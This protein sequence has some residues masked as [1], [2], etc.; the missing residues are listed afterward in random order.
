M[1]L[2]LLKAGSCLSSIAAATMPMCTTAQT[3]IDTETAVP[4]ATSSS[5]DITIAEDGSI[6]LAGGSAVTVDSANQ[7]MNEG[8]I[9]I[10]DGDGASGI[11]FVPGVAS[12]L[13]NNGTIQI[14]EDYDIPD[15][16]ANGTADGAIAEAT[17]RHGIYLAPGGML[18]GSI[19]NSGA[20]GVE[21]LGSG[22][23]ML[24]STLDGSLV[25]S[26]TIAVV[27]DNSVGISTADVTGDVAVT[28][29]VIAAGEGASAVVINGDI[30]GSLLLQNTI[31]QTSSVTGDDGYVYSL[32][33]GDLRSGAPTVSVAGNVGSGII[34]GIPPT[35]EDD[36]ND[37]EDGDGVADDEEGTGAIT[38]YGT[39]AALSIGSVDD[40]AIGATA[41]AGGGHSLEVDGTITSNAVY[42]SN[43]T[44]A[45]LIG[46]QGGAVNMAGGI[47]VN[48][49]IQAVTNDSGAT[50]ILIAE[51]A[52][53]PL[54][55]N[56]G[57]II[58]SISAQGD[59]SS[60][61]I[62]D[63]SG[64]LTTI[65]NNG[66]I[67][68]SGSNEDV[69]A[70]LDLSANT[71]GV[72]INQ[73][74]SDYEDTDGDGSVD[75]EEEAIINTSITGDILT[76]SGDDLI[77][78]SDG[79]I[80]GDS[81]LGAGDDAI[82]LSG[83][84]IYLGDAH[85]AAGTA[86]V[87]LA[88]TS[89]FAGALDVADQA[90]TLTIS[91]A[92]TFLG[93]IEGGSALDVEVNGGMFGASS[94]DELSFSSLHIGAD[95]TL[96]AY[97][98]TESG[99]SSLVSVGTAQFDEG[100][101][102]AVTVS[103]LAGVEGEYLVLS[104]D[105]LVGA[106]SF[107]DS[108]ALLPFLLAGNV[109]TDQ[110]AGEILLQIRQK[111]AAELGLNAALASAYPA[112]L[113]LSGVDE[114]IEASFL[115]IADAE[116]LATQLNGLLPDYSGGNFDLAVRGSRLISRHLTDD[117][118]IFAED[119]SSGLWLEGIGLRGGKANGSTAGYD[120][121]AF[122]ISAGYEAVT[123][124][125]N[126]GLS[127]GWL[128]G[129][130]DSTAADASIGA[131]QYELGAFWRTSR[132]PF[133]AFARGS[134]AYLSY[135]S[136]RTFTGAIDATEYTRST[137]GDWNGFLYSG[138]LGA[139]YDWSLGRRLSVLPKVTVDYYKLHESG[140]S[141]SGDG[142]IDLTVA[143]RDSDALSA[144]ATATLAYA[145]GN[146][147]Y[148]DLPL[149]LEIEAGRRTIIDSALGDTVAHFVDGEDF[150]LAGGAYSGGGWLGEARVRGGGYGY[151]WLLGAGA[152]EGDGKMDFTLRASL[153]VGF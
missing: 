109:T 32:S 135:S 39:G 35:D 144:T 25:H 110:D 84:G 68:A 145:L 105:E 86:T 103:S 60:H 94:A 149:T 51:D 130:N 74:S 73:F 133:Y 102:L 70:A 57:T 15:E 131:S 143:S 5:G 2:T 136:E 28:G 9:D 27:G 3:T 127:L 98:D 8:L 88:D 115:E 107:S 139:S 21:G 126:V 29:S 67:T 41:G 7:V 72:L 99:T 61:A 23:I 64:T 89:I 16:D 76:G 95:G 12:D 78:V 121:S 4:L 1:K 50:A 56:G 58:S 33:R 62:R 10:G 6:V 91:D 85:F 148:G 114:Y 43:D 141:E 19:E 71:T 113:A 142:V 153:A 125:G 96:A 83:D 128:S 48:G 18:T 87:S 20:I 11:T 150:T 44:V 17:G 124:I 13:V 65:N 55:D 100:S 59:G 122:G 54:I 80:Y 52:N 47:G 120:L 111:T 108:E 49:T 116:T 151:A 79:R 36:G 31:A 138:A 38:A 37:D 106:P 30:G 147:S 93:T 14:L 146:S 26:G 66:Y 53:V 42:S 92:A 22:G 137:A 34:I 101:Q 77:T 75:A 134:A 40:I 140:Y 117:R 129:S 97:V 104:A 90:A 45:L 152:E 24:E 46:G 123:G 119:F 112:A 82:R 63:L 132:G 69:V 81:Y 118:S